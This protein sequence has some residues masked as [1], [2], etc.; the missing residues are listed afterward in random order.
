[1][2]LVRVG[3]RGGPAPASETRLTDWRW[4]VLGNERALGGRVFVGCEDVCGHHVV[5]LGSVRI[6]Q[7]LGA[8][9]GSSGQS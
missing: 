9:G 8:H 5:G 1:M 3:V 7:S 4:M 6:P 2:F